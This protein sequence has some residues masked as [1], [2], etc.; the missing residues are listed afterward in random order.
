[1][2]QFGISP[3]RATPKGHKSFISRTAPHQ[4]ALPTSSSSPCSW[5]TDRKFTAL[6]DEVFKSEGPDRA[7]RSAGT[8]NERDHGT[9]GGQVRRE[10]LD[11]I[12]IIN[13]HHLRKFLAEYE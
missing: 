6:F 13:E 1:M 9:L 3:H 7:H 2:R 10:I 4:R 8:S 5:H 11:R 12:L